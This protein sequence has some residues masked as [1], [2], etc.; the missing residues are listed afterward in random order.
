MKANTSQL[1]HEYIPRHIYKFG[2]YLRTRH[3]SQPTNNPTKT[4]TTMW[5]L[6]TLTVCSCQFD[7]M[8][9]CYELRGSGYESSCSH[10]K[11]SHTNKLGYTN[12]TIAN[13]EKIL[14]RNVT[15]SQQETLKPPKTK[16]TKKSKETNK[17]I[18]EN[19]ASTPETST[20]M[21]V[22]QTWTNIQ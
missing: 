19:K 16:N 3:D 13:N 1:E 18:S 9:E 20:P 11:H 12:R 17:P 8:V 15:I 21:P 22:P 6:K 7:Q 5:R 14:P 2:Q 4:D 10:W